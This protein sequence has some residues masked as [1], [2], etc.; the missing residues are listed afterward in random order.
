MSKPK[1]L[2]QAT[3]R[4]LHPIHEPHVQPLNLL[5]GAG[6]TKLAAAAGRP[7]SGGETVIAS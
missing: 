1:D 3:F 4:K 5:S 7:D 2:R 6:D